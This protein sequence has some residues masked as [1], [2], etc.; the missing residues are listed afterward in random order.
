MKNELLPLI[1][2]ILSSE[3]YPGFVQWIE[4]KAQMYKDTGFRAKEESVRWEN[5]GKHDALMSLLNDFKLMGKK[6]PE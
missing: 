3:Y 1:R 5:V 4:D 6:K 2:L